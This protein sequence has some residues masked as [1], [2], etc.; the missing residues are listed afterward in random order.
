MNENT[1]YIFKRLAV[2]LSIVLVLSILIAFLVSKTS[3]HLSFFIIIFIFIAILSF[4]KTEY[5]IYLLLFSM[6]LSPEITLGAVGSGVSLATS[7]QLVIR[8]EDVILIIIGLSW[9]AKTAIHKELGLILRT[10]LNKPIAFYILACAFPTFLGALFGR[11]QFKAGTL[12]LIKYLE[13]FV[14]YFMI[15]NYVDKE[16]IA[17][18]FINVAFITALLVALFAIYQIPS[19]SRVT[20]PFEGENGEPNTLG[21]YLI[22]MIAIAFGLFLNQPKIWDKLKWGSFCFI[23]FIPFLYTLSRSSWLA[24]IPMVITFILMSKRKVFLLLLLS[25]AG[26]ILLLLSPQA[27]MERFSYT[28]DPPYHAD[29][30]NIGDTRLDTSASARIYSWKMGLKGWTKHPIFGYGITG[31]FFMDAQYIRILVE[32]GLLGIISFLLLLSYVFKETWK[33]HKQIHI[34]FYK[35]L[36]MG[37]IAGFIALCTHSIGA[38]TF[39]IIRIMEPFWFFTAIIILLPQIVLQK[40]KLPEIEHNKR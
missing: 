23:L 17:K 40:R 11:V 18:K 16:K 35:G 7:R 36:T 6:L 27:V 2:P 10:P 25:F 15:V 21:G 24:A 9:L 4:I 14:I 37:Y 39:I 1:L 28:F 5:A 26:I 8:F 33:I 13:Y 3:S 29:Q 20:A 34:P 32:T 12:Y 31:Y 30:I 19:G 38:N 22:F